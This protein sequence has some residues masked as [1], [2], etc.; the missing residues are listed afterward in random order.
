MT[1]QVVAIIQARLGSRR[2][3]KKAL[4]KMNGEPL[5]AHVVNRVRKVSSVH[6]VVVAV[7]NK[8]LELISLLKSLKVK[9]VLGPEHDVLMRF[10]LATLTHRA[11]VIMRVTGDCPLWSP[12]AGEGVL[13][14]FLNDP[15]SRDFWSN[16][17]LTTGWPDGTDT[18]VFSR[19]LL[20]RARNARA[21]MSRSDREHVT[22]WM[23]REVGN[24]AGI[25]ER[26]Y[27]K[28][29][30]LK[31]S[32]DTPEDLRRIARLSNKVTSVANSRY[33]LGDKTYHV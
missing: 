31:L 30:D 25:Y 28:T 33:G 21:S 12:L 22:S 10:W 8:D 3:P 9:I 14:E 19:S 5:I 18:E 26:V 20:N 2:F 32:V 4:A 17:T 6:T 27:D 24:R 29:S 11:D 15:T 13:Q 23:R 1:K 16:D 7:P